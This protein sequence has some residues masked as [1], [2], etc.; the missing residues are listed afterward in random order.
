MLLLQFKRLGDLADQYVLFKLTCLT[1]ITKLFWWAR[2]VIATRISITSS[3]VKAWRAGA[4]VNYKAIIK[5]FFQMNALHITEHTMC[6]HKPAKPV[7]PS[8]DPPHRKNNSFYYLH[9][10]DENMVI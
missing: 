4:V 6:I 7:I 5:L 8:L 9:V 2:A 1:V 3:L 10:F